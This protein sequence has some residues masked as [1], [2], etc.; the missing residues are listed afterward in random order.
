[1]FRHVVLFTWTPDA[2]EAQRQTVADELRKL[3]GLIPELRGYAVGPD[4]GITEGNYDFAVVADFDDPAGYAVYRDHPTHRAV[5][6]KHIAPIAAARAR[7]QY[8]TGP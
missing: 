7:V 1:M 8:V 5:A 2:T 4:A 3:P 6:D